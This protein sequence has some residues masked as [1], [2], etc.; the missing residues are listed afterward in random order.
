MAWIFCDPHERGGLIL[1]IVES[2]KINPQKWVSC[3]TPL[4]TVHPFQS[5]PGRLEKE[6][7]LNVRNF[8]QDCTC[9]NAKKIAPKQIFEL[10]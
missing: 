5:P 8:D 9:L 7:H 4:Y 1:N 2:E 10:L 3:R 6:S